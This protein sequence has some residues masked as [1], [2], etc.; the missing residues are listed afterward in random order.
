MRNV[1]V[2]TDFSNEDF[3]DLSVTRHCGGSAIGRVGINGVFAALAQK[4]ASMAL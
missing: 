2:V 4:Q 3:L 1:E